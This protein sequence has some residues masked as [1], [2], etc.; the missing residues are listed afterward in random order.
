[1]VMQWIRW[2]GAFRIEAVT[3]LSEYIHSEENILNTDIGKTKTAN[4]GG[5][6]I[7]IRAV[8]TEEANIFVRF[9]NS[10]IFTGSGIY[11]LRT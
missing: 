11:F 1:M 4:R 8:F 7:A 5:I 6:A 3:H 9:Q 10:L 2:I